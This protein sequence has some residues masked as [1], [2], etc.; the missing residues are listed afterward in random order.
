MNVADSSL[1]SVTSVKMKEIGRSEEPGCDL[2]VNN[3][4]T[5]KKQLLN[6]CFEKEVPPMRAQRCLAIAGSALTILLAL[7]GCQSP[8][9]EQP[10]S[11][12]V[13]TSTTSPA[14]TSEQNSAAPSTDLTT[15]ASTTD[16]ADPNSNL[17][18]DV[19]SALEVK[20]R[21]PKTGYSRD[22]FGPAWADVDRNGCDTRN[23][24]LNR[25]LEQVAYRDNTQNCVVI[26]GVLNDPY[27]AT[28]INFQRGQDT[29]TAVQIDHVVALSDAWQKGAQQ[30]TAEQ[31]RLFSND[32]L[33]LLAVDGPANQQKSDS[34]AA[35]WLPGNTAFRCD[36]VSRQVAVKHRYDLWVT[37]AEKDAIARV[38]E[39]CPGQ[40][41]PTDDTVYTITATATTT[42]EQPPVA[43]VVEQPAPEQPAPVQPAAVA[44]APAPAGTDPRFPNCKQAIAAGYGNYIQGVNPEYDWYRDGDNDGINCER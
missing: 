19:L 41:V 35:S 26:T 15:P 38:L 5:L 9:S 13:S 39:A 43:P 33:N 10:T 44:P 30:L 21:A 37:A 3:T 42:V 11:S 31:R 22:E 6:Y 34:D 2:S 25:D 32:P 12:P 27:T 4:C 36:Y 28:Q 40:E 18:V 24:I 29:S 17:A 23:D 16:T 14:P 1:V 7:T 8:D 20:G